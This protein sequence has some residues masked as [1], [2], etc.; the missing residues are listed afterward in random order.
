MATDDRDTDESDEQAGPDETPTTYANA[1]REEGDRTRQ[2]AW[3]AR[4][5]APGEPDALRARD[6]QQSDQRYGTNQPSQP[7]R[8]Y[9][10]QA[11]Q[12]GTGGGRGRANAPRG[13]EEQGRT[14]PSNR[15]EPT[16]PKRTQPLREPSEPEPSER[17]SSERRE[18]EHRAERRAES[19]RREESEREERLPEDEA[20]SQSDVPKYGGPRDR[21][22]GRRGQSD[23]SVERQRERREYERRFD[24]QRARQRDFQRDK[25]G[26]KYRRR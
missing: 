10:S 6:R 26:G 16:P 17:K 3:D 1:G 15:T 24:K 11:P 12:G 22:R 4:N 25:S 7:S 14:E 8:R 9:G 5:D 21:T 18:G 20:E 2:Q 19:E 13:G 23:Q